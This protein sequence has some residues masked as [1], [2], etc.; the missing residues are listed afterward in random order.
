MQYILYTI[1][2]DVH[3]QL[4]EKGTPII[5]LLAMLSSNPG[6]FEKFQSNP[7]EVLQMFIPMLRQNPAAGQMLSGIFASANAQRT[8]ML[9]LIK[10]DVAEIDRYAVEFIDGFIELFLLYLRLSLCHDLVNSFG[11]FK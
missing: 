11:L 8:T 2:R 10:T 3:G 7:F 9:G 1:E 6:V 4:I 5:M